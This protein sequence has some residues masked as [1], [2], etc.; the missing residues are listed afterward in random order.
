MPFKSAN[1]MVKPFE[2]KGN[3]M[4]FVSQ[5]KVRKCKYCENQPKINMSSG[6]NKGYYKTCGSIEC[7]RKQYDDFMFAKKTTSCQGVCRSDA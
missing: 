4:V 2:Q 6:R 1:A 7:L 3:I 5:N